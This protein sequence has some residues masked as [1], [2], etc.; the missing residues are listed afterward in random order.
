MK[1][2]HIDRIFIRKN[3]SRRLDTEHVSHP[4]PVLGIQD[5]PFGEADSDS[6]FEELN[7]PFAIFRNVYRAGSHQSRS[8]DSAIHEEKKLRCCFFGGRNKRKIVFQ[9]LLLI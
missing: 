9:S 6:L 3:D 1:T 2:A 7:V 8:V 5:P 4:A